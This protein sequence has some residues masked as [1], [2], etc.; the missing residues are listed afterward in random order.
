MVLGLNPVNRFSVATDEPS[1][2]VSINVQLLPTI[3]LSA[4]K[5]SATLK[6]AAIPLLTSYGKFLLI[7][8]ADAE[9]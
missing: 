1:L 7:V 8:T 6:L 3:R 4:Y 5:L 9:S 2:T